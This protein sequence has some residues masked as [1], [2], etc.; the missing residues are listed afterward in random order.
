MESNGVNLQKD[1]GQ[2]QLVLLAEM[3]ELSANPQ[4][5]SLWPLPGGEGNS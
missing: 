4:V 1:C 5:A 2:D 3:R